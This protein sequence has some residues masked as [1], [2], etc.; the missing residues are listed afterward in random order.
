MNSLDQ[1]VDHYNRIK[2]NTK[3]VE[4]EL[5]EKEV[6]EIDLQLE[7]AEHALS[8]NSQG[9]RCNTIR[10]FFHF[11]NFLS[12]DPGI[13]NYMENLRGV[14]TDLSMRVSKSQQNVT[15][16]QKMMDKWNDKPMFVRCNEPKAEGLLNM[17]GGTKASLSLKLYVLV[18]SLPKYRNH[19]SSG[20]ILKIHPGSNHCTKM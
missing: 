12:F 11:F 16:I 7:K 10:L 15:T 18:P 14:V 20:R 9:I 1:T 8:W 19:C 3:P 13:W 5:V 17:K 6:A 2:N 4:F